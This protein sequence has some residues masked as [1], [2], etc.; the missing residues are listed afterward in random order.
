M[1][2][3][4]TAITPPAVLARANRFCRRLVR[5][6]AKNFYY[7]F[8]LL[9][10]R[11]Q[12][13]VYA[14]YTFCR[15]LDD[16]VDL[17]TA[18][19]AS[20][21]SLRARFGRIVSGTGRLDQR[22]RLTCLAL[23]EAARQF[24]ITSRHLDW[25]IEGV[26]MDCSVRRYETMKELRKYL[27]GVAAAVG[28]TCLEIF[29]YRSRRARRFAVYLGYAMQ[30]TNIIRDVK[31][32]F[33]RG[34]VYLPQEDLRRFGVA[35]TEL[36]GDRTSPAVGRLLTFE[37]DRARRYFTAARGLWPLL[38]RRSAP[39]PYALALIYGALLNTMERNGFT[40]LE[41]RFSIPSWQKVALMARATWAF[42]W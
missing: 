5:E 29:G 33:L 10:Q 40:V 14:L 20:Q 6:E 42:L 32:D 34:R 41:G 1:N 27:F 36:G 15:L 22:D 26:L 17:S 11:K 37:A 30:L 35:E 16:A 39:C 9:P 4:D 23:G 18:G 21:A 8:L 12:R 3:Y 2:L 25:I 19:A 13:A 28:L 24:P 31:E 7:G 38:D